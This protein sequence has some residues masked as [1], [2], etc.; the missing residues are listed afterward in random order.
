MRKNNRITVYSLA[1]LCVVAHAVVDAGGAPS[2]AEHPSHQPP[3]HDHHGAQE[4]STWWQRTTST[5]AV[6]TGRRLLRITR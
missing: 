6:G 5:I 4:D 1:P 3:H 2:D